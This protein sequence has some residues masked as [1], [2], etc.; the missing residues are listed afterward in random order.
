VFGISPTSSTGN[1][2][3]FSDPNE[4]VQL[5]KSTYM[6]ILSLVFTLWL[7]AALRDY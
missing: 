3:G 2:S 1:G 6:L 5:N 7:A 4:A